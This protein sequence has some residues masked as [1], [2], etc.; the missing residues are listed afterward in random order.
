M[1]YHAFDGYMGHALPLGG[2]CKQEKEFLG[3]IVQSINTEG[4]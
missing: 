3:L 1:Y 2:S 4:G